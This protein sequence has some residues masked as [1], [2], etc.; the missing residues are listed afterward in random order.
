MPT[1]LK[2]GIDKPRVAPQKFA[3]KL[4]S[5]TVLSS[6]FHYLEFETDTPFNFE[7]GQYINAIVAEHTFRAYSI[8]GKISDTRFSLLVDT[9]PGGPGSQFF[10][11]LHPGDSMT[12]LGPLGVFIIREND[13][14]E[15]ILLLGTGSGMS[16]LKCIVDEMFKEGNYS[17][18]VYLYMGLTFTHEIFWKE[19]FEALAEKYPNFHFS[20]AIL[21]P[22]EDWQGHKGFNTDFIKLDFSDAKSC[23]AYMCGHPAMIEGAKE[24]LLS[25]GCPKERLYE[26]KFFAQK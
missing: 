14:S 3:S 15:N 1:I 24:I 8:A 2:E 9:R 23:S 4:L 21:N 7:P 17:K 5:N 26:E 22:E 19:H 16:P 6:K 10:E 12:F 18:P 13:G 11:N 25:S 20:L